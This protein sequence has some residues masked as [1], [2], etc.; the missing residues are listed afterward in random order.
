MVSVRLTLGSLR[1]KERSRD[2]R[3]C[4]SRENTLEVKFYLLRNLNGIIVSMTW[5]IQSL[6]YVHC[7]SSRS[8]R[9]RRCSGWCWE[10]WCRPR[11][12][13]GSSWRPRWCRDSAD[14]WLDGEE[15]DS[16]FEICTVTRVAQPP[17]QIRLK[18]SFTL[19]VFILNL[20]CMLH[21]SIK[22]FL[23]CY[24][25]LLSHCPRLIPSERAS[26]QLIK[27]C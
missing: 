23:C 22:I 19:S 4:R 12:W 13:F 24:F 11:R 27:L 9:P 26:I 18:L 3:I 1:P 7:P 15:G 5:Q 16:F 17:R 6:F 2:F 25:M 8:S 20:S 14:G 21:F 10:C